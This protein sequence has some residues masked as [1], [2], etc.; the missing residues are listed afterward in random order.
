MCLPEEFFKEELQGLSEDGKTLI[1]K[2]SNDVTTAT[3][4][5]EKFKCDVHGETNK[6]IK[7]DGEHAFCT[8]CLSTLLLQH[9]DMLE[10]LE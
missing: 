1:M 2:A 4:I 9:L 7:F 3:L 5:D 8:V 10:P 6:I